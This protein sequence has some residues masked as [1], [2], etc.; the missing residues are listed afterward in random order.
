MLTL[1]ISLGLLSLILAILT[2]TT[3]A[4]KLRQLFRLISGGALGS[5]VA[6]LFSPAGLTLQSCA[7][8]GLYLLLIVV[9]DY[10]IRLQKRARVTT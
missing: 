4:H 9:A 7:K 6:L 2:V 5:G 8:L 10:R 3:R 1:H